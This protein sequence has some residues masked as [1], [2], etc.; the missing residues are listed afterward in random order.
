MRLQLLADVVLRMAGGAFKF[1]T[2]QKI[3]VL[4]VARTGLNPHSQWSLDPSWIPEPELYAVRT[5]NKH[6]T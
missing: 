6:Q 5:K 4:S 3:H 2:V 1:D